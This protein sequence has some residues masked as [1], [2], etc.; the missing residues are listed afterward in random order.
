MIV[1]AGLVMLI[2]SMFLNQ[3]NFQESVI[4]ESDFVDSLQVIE[5]D[6]Q[7]QVEQF[8]KTQDSLQRALSEKDSLIIQEKVVLVQIADKI[9]HN[10]NT[11]WDNLSPQQRYNYIDYAITQIQNQ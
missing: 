10:L 1:I 7:K 5:Q 6:Y 3:D 11:D 2:L 4:P 8:Q 9:Q